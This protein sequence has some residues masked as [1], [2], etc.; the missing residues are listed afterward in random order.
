MAK[1]K[2]LRNP[3]ILPFDYVSILLNWRTNSP[4]TATPTFTVA[5]VLGGTFPFNA[6]MLSF[7]AVDSSSSIS[8]VFQS[9]FDINTSPWQF[10]LELA[11]TTTVSKFR[12]TAVY[13]GSNNQV[14][15]KFNVGVLTINTSY[16]VVFTAKRYRPT[17]QYL[18]QLA[19]AAQNPVTI[20]SIG[21]S[22]EIPTPPATNYANGIAMGFY[23]TAPSNF[24]IS[25]IERRSN[26]DFTTNAT[27]WITQVVKL[28]AAL[29]TN[30][31]TILYSSGLL[32][33]ATVSVNVSIPIAA[34]DVIAVF[35]QYSTSVS[36]SNFFANPVNSYASTINGTPVTLNR[37]ARF[38]EELG[39]TSTN[40]TD[41][42]GFNPII[43]TTKLFIG[44]APTWSN[45][46]Y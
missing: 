17:T 12:P 6:R 28:N 42:T 16:P 30:N 10:E 8:F 14:T 11:F 9:P 45:L 46:I 29:P 4:L 2:N 35:S 21:A 39:F 40:F 18:A 31:N 41:G 20:S 34:N 44:G 15:V 36:N 23:F 24:T 5:E 32:T 25:A 43:G 19:T 13:N 27:S 3:D 33:P 26:I 22:S 1:R 38:P 7:T 37:I